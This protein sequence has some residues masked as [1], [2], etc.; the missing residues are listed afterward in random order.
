VV[1][2]SN[3][4]WLQNSPGSAISIFGRYI[5][6]SDWITRK[7]QSK[8]PFFL[9]FLFM[10][11]RLIDISI[12]RTCTESWM[13]SNRS[14]IRRVSVFHLKQRGFQTT[15]FLDP[16]INICFRIGPW[17]PGIDNTIQIRIQVEIHSRHFLG[18]NFCFC[19]VLQL[20]RTGG[21][22]LNRKFRPFESDNQIL[23]RI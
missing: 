15:I 18:L 2:N 3:S 5:S 11:V 19:F 10:V 8:E 23:V 22:Y 4:S 13:H 20:V 12:N 6:F 9:L 7:I 17:E 14:R 1:R 21:T 16:K